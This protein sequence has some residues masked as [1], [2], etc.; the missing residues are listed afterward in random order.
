MP[1][2]EIEEV[3][4]FLESIKI[5]G[6]DIDGIEATLKQRLPVAFFKIRLAKKYSVSYK[7]VG[8]PLSAKYEPWTE[9]IYRYYK[10]RGN[11][12][13]FPF[14]RQD[15]W[16]HIHRKQKIFKGLIYTTKKTTVT[17]SD[18]FRVIKPAHKHTFGMQ[19]L[20]IIRTDE[21]ID[22]YNFN[23]LDL[24]EFIGISVKIMNMPIRRDT[25][26]TN[27]YWKHSVRK[28]CKPSQ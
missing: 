3:L 19:A 11:E 8:L 9:Q 5:K 2:Q 17:T 23:P 18:K 24:T 14:S 28:L 16:E 27:D 25:S 22:R 13:V 6:A 4:G 21:L 7:M 1:T 10:K 12:L 15:V 20:R 26:K